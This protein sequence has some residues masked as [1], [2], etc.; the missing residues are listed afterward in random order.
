MVEY[1]AGRVFALNQPGE[2]RVAWGNL[3]NSYNA[4]TQADGV[5]C[6]QEPTT[7]TNIE[8]EI[9]SAWILKRNA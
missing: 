9:F 6:S 1:P 8:Y 3:Y 5:N 2:Y 7:E 4:F